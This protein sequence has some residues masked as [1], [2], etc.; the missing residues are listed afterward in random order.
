[1]KR[2]IVEKHPPGGAFFQTV[3]CGGGNINRGKRINFFASFAPLYISSSAPQS[4]RKDPPGGALLR[5]R[6]YR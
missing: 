6:P 1:M 5:S 4:E 2:L 3:G